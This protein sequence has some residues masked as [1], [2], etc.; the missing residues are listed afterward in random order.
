[1]T[2]DRDH[3][4]TS[5]APTTPI[6][7]AS[8]PS[9]GHSRS[10]TTS[11][12]GSR[13]APGVV[14]ADRYR[15][16]SQL[17][18]GGMGEV[19]RAD[20]LE[21]GSSVALKFLP[22]QLAADP[23]RL[24]RLRAEVRM[25]R[26]VSHANVCRVFDIAQAPGAAGLPI[27]FLTM[28][29][30]DGEDLASLLKRIGRLPADKA[31]QTAR[32][33][34]FGLAAAHEQGLVHRDLKPANIMIDGRGNARIMD[35]GVAGV[36]EELAARGDI[37]AGTPIY[38]APEQL[39]GREVTP[40][41]D[42]YSLGHVLYE[43]F[44]GKPAFS[45]DATRSLAAIK[46]LH[47]SGVTVTRPSEHI[48]LDP[49]V[50]RVILHCLDTDPA[51]R[52]PSAI[53]VAAALPGGDPLAAA[54]AAGETPS[55]ELVA[56][57]GAAGLIRPAIAWSVCAAAII[58]F[59][60][61]AALNDVFTVHR[62]TVFSTPPEAL[63]AKCRDMLAKFAPGIAVPAHEAWGFVYDTAV[64]RELRGSDDPERF[65]RIRD[66]DPAPIL[67]WYRASRD[68]I[69]PLEWWQRA[70]TP[71][72]PPRQA[73]G[74]F[75]ISIDTAGRLSRFERY[76]D[77]SDPKPVPDVTDWAPFF[78]AADLP[79][80]A[81]TARAPNRPP[82]VAA[83]ARAA[84]T[85]PTPRDDTARRIDAASLAGTPV[86]FDVDVDR[87]EAAA[88]AAQNETN[89]LQIFASLML[90]IGI[91]IAVYMAR[92]NVL[93]RRGD[94]RGAARLALFVIVAEFLSSVLPRN[95]LADIFT[96]DVFGRPA[97]RA[98][99]IGALVWLLY[100]ALEPLARRAWPRLMISWSRAAGAEFRDPLVARHV[101]FGMAA[102]LV[103]TTLYHIPRV[104]VHWND[105]AH[106][107]TLPTE[108]GHF[109]G[110]R[111]SLSIALNS[112][113]ANVTVGL[114]LGF[115]AVGLRSFLQ[116]AWLV[117][118]LFWAA[119]FFMLFLPDSANLFEAINGGIA[120]AIVT[121]ILF[122]A[123]LLPFAVALFTASAFLR[124][125]LTLDLGVWYASI[126]VLFAIPTGA[127][128]I[129][130]ARFASGSARRA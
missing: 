83:D 94:R 28:E 85:G 81:F 15:I 99:W 59:I 43:L 78:A 13:L 89:Y 72:A 41:S 101:L 23:V 114:L 48:D 104:F 10:P 87:P 67:F 126:T 90:F 127:A 30:V 36:A 20:D 7:A 118:P 121:A 95:S 5:D 74:G 117:A 9:G 128:L 6:G 37:A 50:E 76:V 122:N 33:I 120:A 57:S 97:A 14:L 88:P 63:A 40:R 58:A 17:G 52:P 69:T 47:S 119:I 109:V 73:S 38:M 34:C 106:A 61:L 32:Q 29:F 92:A 125:P 80:G 1:M 108:L 56:R 26:Q 11:G 45:P 18:K 62:R 96:F 44:T 12:T 8:G 64:S 82:N 55:P 98:L 21:L 115:L 2:A 91:L 70:V 24:D 84:W 107:T 49:A 71:S 79:F 39:E 25:A 130:S 110:V 4:V 86:L 27:S 116:K 100:M 103:C 35:F 123:G 66:A 129:A 60:G 77:S 51:A 68:R 46:A 19:Y 111:H 53:A 105:W 3:D 31:V 22:S 93:A 42:I 16:V 65:D 124:V 113:S 54:I 102:G 75:Y 112:V